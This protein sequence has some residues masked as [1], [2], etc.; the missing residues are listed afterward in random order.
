MI[1]SHTV[2]GLITA[3]GSSKGVPRKNL[4]NLTGRTL[5]DWTIEPALR[6]RFIDR[7]IISSDDE[8]ILAVARDT[9][10]EVPFVRPAKLAEDDTPHA[11]V[12]S[13]ALAEIDEEYDYVVLLQPTS[14][15]RRTE[16][17]DAC[18]ELCHAKGAP[19][20]VSVTKFDKN[21]HSIME[22]DTEGKVRA[23]LNGSSRP[24]RRQDTDT[25]ILNGAVYVCRC[26]WWKRNESFLSRQTLAYIMPFE[27]SID[28]DS[29]FDFEIAEMLLSRDVHA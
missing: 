9:G 26:D 22:I 12:I 21:L 18:I 24:T 10:C 19:S 15:L 27:R 1:E 2:L 7:L 14:P 25:Y 23:I 13:H 16:D 6:S 8:E 5:I 4:M 29:D 20:A 17:I 11:E 28:I 3:R